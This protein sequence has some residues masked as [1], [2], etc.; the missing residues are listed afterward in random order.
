[1][2]EVE[3]HKGVFRGDLMGEGFL[4]FVAEK[5]W[6]PYRSRFLNGLTNANNMQSSWIHN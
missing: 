2:G 5:G 6:V 4:F 3:G 1:M